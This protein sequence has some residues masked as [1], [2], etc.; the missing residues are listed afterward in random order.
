MKLPF[1]APLSVC[2]TTGRR[3]APTL[4]PNQQSV[5]NLGLKVSLPPQA[6]CNRTH[7]AFV[8]TNSHTCSRSISPKPNTIEYA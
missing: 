7:P 4:P 1:P 5:S 2:L 3:G 8:L 6:N